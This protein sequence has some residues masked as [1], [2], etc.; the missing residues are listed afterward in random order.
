M[1]PIKMTKILAAA[2]ATATAA[3][4]P[5]AM[6]QDAAAAQQ[7]AQ[8]AAPVSDKEVKKFVKAEKKINAI[9]QEWTPKVQSAESQEQAQEMQQTAQTE[10][11]AAIEKQGLSVQRYNAIAQQAQKD[12]QL[13]QRLQQEA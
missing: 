5:A 12:P 3:A 4:S 10:M 13:A 8:E 1:T 9:I 11:I 7:Q 6:A 2:A